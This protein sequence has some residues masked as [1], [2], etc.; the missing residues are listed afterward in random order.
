MKAERDGLLEEA[1]PA[2]SVLESV[3]ML[4]KLKSI[5]SGLPVPCGPKAWFRKFANRRQVAAYAGLAP[6][7]WKSGTIGQRFSA[8]RRFGAN[9]RPLNIASL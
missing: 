7:H 4:L 2:G 6:T 9:R 3:R 8:M 5:G 1:P